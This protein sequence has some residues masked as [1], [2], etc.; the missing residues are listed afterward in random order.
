MI[1][2]QPEMTETMKLKL[3]YSVSQATAEQKWHKLVFDPNTIK[4]R[5]SP[6]RTQTRIRNL[7]GEKAQT[8]TDSLFHAKLPEKLQWSVNLARLRN[9]AYDE[10]VMNLNRELEFNGLEESDDIPVPTM[11]LVPATSRPANGLL[12]SG[13]DP[14]TTGNYL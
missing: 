5:D 2:C 8:E 4:L 7:F 10:I 9:A 6:R 11:S 12:S 3:F 1:H 13:N 14:R